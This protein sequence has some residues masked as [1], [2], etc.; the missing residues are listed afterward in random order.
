MPSRAI[1]LFTFVGALAGAISFF[2]GQSQ[3]FDVFCAASRALLRGH[4]LYTLNAADYFKY[5]PT[6]AL[7]FEPLAWLR[8]PLGA[9]LWGALNF[10][11]CALG[12]ER[13][14]GDRT[15]RLAQGLALAGIV[16]A[17]DGDQSNLLVVGL[18]L[19][20]LVAWEKQQ[21]RLFAHLVAAATLVKLFPIA[22]VALVVLRPQ[23]GKAICELALAF[24]AWTLL[25]LVVIGPHALLAQY[26]SWLALLARDHGNHGWSVMTLL[27]DGL[28]VGWSSAA[29]QLVALCMQCT[30][31]AFALRFGADRAFVRTL[32]ASLLVFA[33][34]FNHR[35]EYATFVVSA[36][37]IA[38]AYS[39]GLLPRSAPWRVLVLLAILAPGPLF[40]RH[41]PGTH[42]M[43][44]F[45]A[46]HRLFHPLR[47]VPL[48]F[49]WGGLQATMLARF[50]EIRIRV[51][52]PSEVQHA[53]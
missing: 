9:V 14:V 41:E 16:V 50:F 2:A 27:Q 37:A 17:T 34:L 24:A 38:L 19:L 1:A 6:F 45:L 5:S 22:L 35:S 8:P 44:A 46:A 36:V 32:F 53:S 28:H 20:A 23:K 39:E 13:V 12:L 25:P 7:L 3:N 4:D 42:G 40:A 52:R 33:V 48:L 47:V 30:P 51:R 18:A 26:G 43:L 21:P 10:G 29:V 15:R 31:I 11:V 49:L